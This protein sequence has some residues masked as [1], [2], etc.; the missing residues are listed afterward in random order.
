MY[1]IEPVIGTVHLYWKDSFDIVQHSEAGETAGIVD[2]QRFPGLASATE[3]VLILPSGLD[4]LSEVH[5]KLDLRVLNLLSECARRLP[6]Y[7]QIPYEIARQL[8]DKYPNLPVRLVCNSAFFADLPIRERSYALDPHLFKSTYQRFGGDGLCH[9]CAVKSI[10]AQFPQSQKVISIHL[11]NQPS[12]TAWQNDIPVYSS[13][14]YSPLE[15]L[16]SADGCGSI[17]PGIPLMLADSGYSPAEIRR[18]LVENSGWNALFGKRVD[19]NELLDSLPSD[20]SIA[21]DI[22]LDQIMEQIGSA[23]SV[24]GGLDTIVFIVD[25][26][27]ESNT[28]LAGVTSRLGWLG[29]KP[30]SI[31]VVMDG[32]M[33]VSGEGSSIRVL[34]LKYSP[35][36][37]IAPFL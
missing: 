30:L 7:D 4:I 31:P 19:I 15:G 35:V 6:E 10:Q 21:W 36:E 16:M 23:C 11:C 26:L 28:M 37:I 29:Y 32:R 12:I 20:Y 24:M 5:N 8:Y 17:D 13:M 18:L 3:V 1:V 22:L 14:G 27:N 25:Y 34:A 2:V 33:L 9:F